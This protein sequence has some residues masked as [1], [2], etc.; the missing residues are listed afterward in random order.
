MHK[1]D[2]NQNED[3]RMKEFQQRNEYFKFI[4]RNRLQAATAA[5]TLAASTVGG[6]GG[7]ILCDRMSKQCER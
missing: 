2:S 4:I 3:S 6:N 1:F 7:H 5:T